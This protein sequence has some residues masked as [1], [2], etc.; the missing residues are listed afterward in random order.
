M[1]RRPATALVLVMLAVAAHHG[2]EGV[3]AQSGGAAVFVRDLQNPRDRRETRSD[4]LDTPINPGS[5]VKALALVA[6][7]ESGV[8]T[9]GSSQICRRQVK[10]DGQTFVCSHPDLRRAL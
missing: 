8:I 3:A 9:P 4:I 1:A 2:G 7:L 5:T 10:A 6:A